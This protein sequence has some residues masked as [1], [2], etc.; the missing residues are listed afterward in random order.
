VSWSQTGKILAISGG[1]SFVK[2]M[3]EDATGDWKEV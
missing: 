2:V 3:E 1:E